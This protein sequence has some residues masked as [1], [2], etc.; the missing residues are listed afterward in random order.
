[1]SCSFIFLDNPEVLHVAHVVDRRTYVV[2]TETPPLEEASEPAKGE[3]Y[4]H[5]KHHGLK[6]DTGGC[7]GLDGKIVSAFSQETSVTKR[8]CCRTVVER[9]QI[10]LQQAL[11]SKRK[12]TLARCVTLALYV[13][14]RD[15]TIR[16]RNASLGGKIQVGQSG[17]VHH[18][19]QHSRI[20]VTKRRP[21]RV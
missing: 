1:M 17:R 9:L 19:G 14:N 11:E 7:E 20:K 16:R 12:S 4:S 21:R 18:L 3:L 10:Q 13:V 5:R 6:D 2:T 15:V 8:V